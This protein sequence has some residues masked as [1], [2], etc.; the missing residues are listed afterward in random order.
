VLP[1]HLQSIVSKQK[2]A[3]F[4]RIAMPHAQSLLRVARRLTCSLSAAEDLLQE[5]LLS[6]WRSFHQFRPETNIRAW[7]FRI[8][9]NHFYGQGRKLKSTPVTV[10][11]TAECRTF[12]PATDET[13]DNRR[14]VSRAL[15][16]L[17]ADH[18]TVLLLGVVEGFTCREIAE[19]LDVP[20][21]TVMSRL[22]RARQ[23]M[24]SRLSARASGFAYAAKESS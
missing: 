8:L 12:V 3:E 13:L 21:G 6:G 9:F 18:R 4:E 1:P 22:S 11:L 16:S 14:E 23:T 15:Q 19:I 7:L 17:E 5:T 10:P 20:V 2:Q 24:R